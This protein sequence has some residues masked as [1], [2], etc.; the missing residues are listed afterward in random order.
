M[1]CN[2]INTMSKRYSND[3]MKVF[4]Y[5]HHQLFDDSINKDFKTEDRLL[6]NMPT[7][8]CNKNVY[9]DRGG[10]NKRKHSQPAVQQHYVDDDHIFLQSTKRV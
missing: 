8:V 10:N 4:Q 7:T 5:F 3:N 9:I 1:A 6:K 2:K